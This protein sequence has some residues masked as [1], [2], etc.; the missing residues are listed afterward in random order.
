MLKKTLLLL[1]ISISALAGCGKD[2]PAP[3]ACPATTADNAAAVPSE[4]AA[5]KIRI[6]LNADGTVDSIEGNEGGNWEPKLTEQNTPPQ[7]LGTKLATVEVFTHDGSE[8]EVASG[9]VP[10]HSHAGGQNAPWGSH[11]H[12]WVVISGVNT[13]VHC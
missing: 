2:C 12:R 1:G 7:S 10:L 13:L 9:A 11:C 8:N 5:G 3:P 6:T 4:N